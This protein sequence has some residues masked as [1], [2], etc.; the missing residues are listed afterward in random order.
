[1]RAELSRY[2]PREGIELF[3]CLLEREV[4][5]LIGRC[6]NSEEVYHL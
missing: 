5:K 2:L 1:V 4:R 3:K 6:R